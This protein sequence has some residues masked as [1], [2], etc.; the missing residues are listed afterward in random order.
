MNASCLVFWQIMFSFTH[1]F[2]VFFLSLDSEDLDRGSSARTVRHLPAPFPLRNASRASAWKS[3]HV[4]QVPACHRPGGEGKPGLPHQV[5]PRRSRGHSRERGWSLCPLLGCGRHLPR[6]GAQECCSSLPPR[7]GGLSKAQGT[8]KVLLFPFFL[9]FPFCFLCKPFCLPCERHALFTHSHFCFEDCVSFCAVR[10]E[11][12]NNLLMWRPLRFCWPFYVSL[13]SLI[14]WFFFFECGVEPQL[15]S[16]V[17]LW[18]YCDFLS[19]LSPFIPVL[20]ASE[21]KKNFLWGGPRSRAEPTFG[22]F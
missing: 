14:S 6:R 2:F 18:F 1:F 15:P 12:R 3:R 17:C 5:Q 19:C 20:E 22:D 4:A 7:G 8:G 11:A 21:A 16:W 9:C 13:L 10:L